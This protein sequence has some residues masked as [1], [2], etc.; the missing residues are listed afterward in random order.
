MCNHLENV[1][2]QSWL[3]AAQRLSF[4]SNAINP[5]PERS[6][7][8]LR[9]QLSCLH[10]SMWTVMN[11]AVRLHQPSPAPRSELW[12]GQA[13]YLSFSI[14]NNK[15]KTITKYWTGQGGLSLQPGTLHLAAFCTPRTTLHS[16]CVYFF[17]IVSL[18]VWCVIY[19]CMWYLCMCVLY[20]FVVFVCGMYVC[21]WYV[22]LWYLCVCVSLCI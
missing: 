16:V 14:C 22:C 18:S 10:P 20:M 1:I 6:R 9:R 21:V 4:C 12:P 19:V 7:T 15:L 8:K 13:I 17:Y 2:G 5:H 11:Y 3:P